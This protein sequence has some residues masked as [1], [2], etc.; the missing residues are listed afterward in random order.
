M[1]KALNTQSCI[2]DS[3]FPYISIFK[4]SKKAQEALRQTKVDYYLLKEYIY[5]SSLDPSCLVVKTSHDMMRVCI[6][7]NKQS[8]TFLKVT[9]SWLT[10]N[11]LSMSQFIML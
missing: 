7:Q 9:H 4:V 5:T 11:W 8:S 3:P 1:N 2:Q 10:A 6:S